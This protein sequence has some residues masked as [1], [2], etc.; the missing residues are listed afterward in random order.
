[1]SENRN[2]PL[3]LNCDGRTTVISTNRVLDCCRDRD[4]FED[5]RVYFTEFGEELL[6]N[7]RNIRVR[8]ARTLWVYVGIDEVPFNCGFYQISVRYYILIELEACVDVGRSQTFYGIAIPEKDV[9]LYGGE[10]SVT[11]YSSSP[12]NGFCSVGCV[13][14][15][16]SNDPTAVVE[17]VEPIVLG[18]RVEEC[19]RTCPGTNET[20]VLPECITDELGGE[21]VITQ[22]GPRFYASLG[23][24]SVI[25]IERPSQLL[26]QATDY[27][28]P[29]KE[30]GGTGCEE[31]PC[32]LFKNM[33]FPV[34][35]FRAANCCP[36]GDMSGPRYGGNGGNGSSNGGC[37][38]GNSSN[39]G[40]RNSNK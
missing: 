22:E 23:L 17:T 38:C 4:C 20:L 26:V 39:R 8:N 28:V 9:I 5:T 27:S 31:N 37:G 29:D 3:A 12:L 18:Y 13:D 35:Q 7:S 34:N 32:A 15:G 40:D 6:E 25:R 21:V 10:G 2:A 16:A 14:T 11:S 36:G 1:M 24:F 19:P 30:C 33:A